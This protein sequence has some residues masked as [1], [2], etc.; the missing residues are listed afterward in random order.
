MY[1][2]TVPK[3][4]CGGCLSNITN[5]IKKLDADAKVEADFPTKTLKVE[6]GLGE[7]EVAKVIADAGYPPS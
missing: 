7:N 5:A 2:F 1:Q 6:S 3:M 4:S